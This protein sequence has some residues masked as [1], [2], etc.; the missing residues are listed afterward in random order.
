MYEEKDKKELVPLNNFLTPAKNEMVSSPLDAYE[1]A[2]TEKAKADMQAFITI[3]SALVVAKCNVDITSIRCE[4][5]L[6]AQKIVQDLEL[7]LVKGENQALCIV[8]EMLRRVEKY[9]IENGLRIEESK[10]YIEDFETQKRDFEERQLLKLKEHKS[11]LKKDLQKEKL[12]TSLRE[13]ENNYFF[14]RLEDLFFSSEDCDT[15]IGVTGHI[16]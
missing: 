16:E 13:E 6:D 3:Q 1:A 5:A 11:I 14:D 15:T 10:R 8:K 7:F 4:F 9:N 12:E 2:N